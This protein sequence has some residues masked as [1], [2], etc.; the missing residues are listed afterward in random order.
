MTLPCQEALRVTL[1]MQGGEAG[2]GEAAALELVQEGFA[3]FGR[4]DD[5]VPRVRLE[6]G[7]SSVVVRRCQRCHSLHA[8]TVI[9]LLSSGAPGDAYHVL[10]YNTSLSEM[11]NRREAVCLL[12]ETAFAESLRHDL[13]A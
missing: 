11:E 13:G 7:G 3:P 1:T 5:A 10:T 8:M 2:G 12:I 4:G 9:D 6:E